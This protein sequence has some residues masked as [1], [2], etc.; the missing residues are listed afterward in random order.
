MSAFQVTTSKLDDA[1]MTALLSAHHV[2]FMAIAFHDRVTI[3]LVN[4]VYADRWIYGRLEGGADLS[5]L[6]H[7]QWVAFQVSEVD[8]IYDWRTVT[9]RGAVEL[10]SEASH[11]GAGEYRD[12][13]AR[14]RAVV[15]EIMGTRDP[16]PQRTQ[17]FRLH[18]DAMEGQ[19]SQSNARAGLPRP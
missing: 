6:R 16:A 19:S 9:V 11:A 15:P 3:D 10:L 8:G 17:L 12:T 4:Y 1:A 7:H 18:V 14:L 13:L 2:G 5:T